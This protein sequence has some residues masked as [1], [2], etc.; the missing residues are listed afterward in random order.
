MQLLGG[1]EEKWIF[2]LAPLT[3]F[4]LQQI[5]V[6]SECWKDAGNSELADAP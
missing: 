4:A 2:A 5:S 1:H 3:S 6:I